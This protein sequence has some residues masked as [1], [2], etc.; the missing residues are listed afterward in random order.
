MIV[1]GHCLVMDRPMLTPAQAAERARC[2]RSSIMRALESK[3]LRGERDNK[4]RWKISREALD[5]W[6]QYRPVSDRSE[7]GQNT[8]ID[9]PE[10]G[11]VR[12]E[13][14]A[15][16]A[17]IAGLRDRLTD[18]QAERDRL[19]ALLERALEPRPGAKGLLAR[20]FSRID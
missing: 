20:L 11:H 7:T 1:T 9:R 16:R 19:A 5:E 6:T 13:L 14:A 2:G 4:N 10:T 17:E 15:A 18:T 8:D 12:E 3:S